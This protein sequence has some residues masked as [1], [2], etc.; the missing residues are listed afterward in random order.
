MR[1][2]PSCAKRALLAIVVIASS[3]LPMIS[4]VPCHAEAIYFHR[5]DADDNGILELTDAIN[6][7]NFL[8]LGGDTPTCLDAADADGNN[9]LEL[10][11]VIRVLGYLFLGGDPPESPGPPPLQPDDMSKGCGKDN[12]DVHLGCGSYT[13]CP[14]TTIK[15]FSPVHG[16]PGTIVTIQGSN[17]SQPSHLNVV[18]IGG[19][20][21]KVLGGTESELRVVALRDVATGKVEVDNGAGEINASAEDWFRGDTNALANADVESGS[22]LVVGTYTSSGD[23]SAKGLNQKVLVIFCKPND[24]NPEDLAPV[25]ISARQDIINRFSDVNDFFSDISYNEMSVQFD[26]TPD[27]LPMTGNT[28]FYFWIPADIARAQNKLDGIL[29]DPSATTEQINK[30]KDDLNKAKD[31]QNLLQQ[32]DFLFAEASLAAKAIIPSFDLY[33]DYLFVVAGA[34]HRAT[35]FGSHSGY[36]AEWV[37]MGVKFDIDFPSAKGIAYVGQDDDWTTIAHELSHSLGLPDLYGEAYADG[38][39]V[40]GSA[41]PYSMM[42]DSYAAPGHIGPHMDSKLHYYDDSNVVRLKWGSTPTHNVAYDV[43]VHGDS[44]DPPSDLQYHLV[45]ISVGEGL[46][47]TVEVRQRPDGMPG[48]THIFDRNIPLTTPDGDPDPAWGGG[49]I[50]TKE[51]VKFNQ[52]NN[53]ERKITLIPPEGLYQVGDSFVDPARTL[54]ISVESK[55]QN[56]PAIYRIRVQWGVLPSPDPNGQ[57]DLRIEPWHP[58]PWESVD[59]WVNSPKN[60]DTSMGKTIYEFHEVGDDTKPVGQGDR[61]WVKHPNKIYARIHNDGQQD[62]TNVNVIFYVN[63]PPGIG[64]DG[65]WGPFDSVNVPI[66]LKNSSVVVQSNNDWVPSVDRHTCLRV[67]IQ[68][69]QGEV[70]FDNNEAQENINHFDTKS[71]SPYSAIEFDVTVRNPYTVPATFD[72]RARGVPNNWFV[73]LDKDS[74]YL[75]VKGNQAVHVAIW[76]DRT[77]EWEGGNNEKSPNIADIKIEAWGTLPWDYTFPIGGFEAVCHA[78]RD[79]EIQI[80]QAFVEAKAVGVIGVVTPSVGQEIQMVMHVTDPVGDVHTEPFKSTITGSFN[81]TATG[82]FEMPGEYRIQVF[83]LGGSLAS[84]QE[85]AVM[86]VIRP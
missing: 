86:T 27:W 81:H 77:P 1:R 14:Q 72:L 76:T 35:N 66:I 15:G 58:P 10:T 70:T 30:A 69:Q 18:H 49:V 54:T 65:S 16:L 39:R 47:Y 12:D 24:V 82:E 21:A 20:A 73:A 62:A 83:T 80:Q 75:P 60:D 64:D 34:G 42:G 37:S 43:I 29:L 2:Y 26:V 46:F 53:N 32:P 28:D 9:R 63:T 38:T 59:I 17:F 68:P 74:V 41:G 25:G 45:R 6:V 36:H 57:F 22:E 31:S 67:F 78:V 85:S 56:R 13:H 4:Q 11:D 50:I 33:N 84:E 79:V 19:G 44:Q 5:G 48:L 55:L 51:V 71:G 3:L 7:L 52:S 40:V 61:P 8:F 23:L